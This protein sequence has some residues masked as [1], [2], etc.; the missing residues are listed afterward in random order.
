[1]ARTGVLG[2]FAS[3]AHAHPIRSLVRYVRLVR[4]SPF[5][6]VQCPLD[7]AAESNLEPEITVGGD[8]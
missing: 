1:M 3:A 8:K 6:A 4:R 5:S 2:G 7:R